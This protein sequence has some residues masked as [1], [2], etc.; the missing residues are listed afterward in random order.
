MTELQ[1]REGLGIDAGARDVKAWQQERVA[2]AGGDE[3]LRERHLW[4]YCVG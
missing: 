1:A 2:A 4:I 3:K